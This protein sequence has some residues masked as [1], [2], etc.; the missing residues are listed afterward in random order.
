M[1]ERLRN[2]SNLPPF[3]SISRALAFAFAPLLIG[4]LIYGTYKTGPW[5]DEFW[6][7]FFSDPAVGFKDAFTN[8]WALDVHPP[9]FSFLAWLA[10]NLGLPRTIEAGRLLNF[11]PMVLAAAFVFL[12][13]KR[14]PAE[15]PFL[16]VYFPG[17]A[18][19]WQFPSAFIEF[20]SYF[21]ALCG[22]SL[23]LVCLKRIDRQKRDPLTGSNA[24]L[25]WSGYAA[26]LLICLN[27][28]FV[29]TLLAVGAVAT[30]AFA[31]LL[32]GD[33]RL[34][35]THLA[36][37]IACSLPLVVTTL[38]QWSYL[39]S[40]SKDFWLKTSTQEALILFAEAM[41]IPLVQ[42]T[43][44]QASW[45]IPLGLR[46]LQREGNRNDDIFAAILAASFIVGCA[47]VLAYTAATGA[48]TPRYIMP[49]CI[50][51]VALLSALTAT[52]MSRYRL[53]YA[54]FLTACLVSAIQTTLQT[55]QDLKW[56]EAADY[57]SARQKACPSARITPVRINPQD[58]TANGLASYG[59]A[60][61]YLAKQR[62]MTI[63]AV[64]MPPAAPKST[65]CPDYYWI[66]NLASSGQSTTALSALITK[67][68]PNLN[69]CNIKMTRFGLDA[70]V[71][72]VAD[73]AP[74][75]Q[76]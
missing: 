75:C 19:L 25:V 63:G 42:S 1:S 14:N 43:L 49:V 23:L 46:V 44:L 35:L 11:I 13:W 17:V 64:D 45:L 4:M 10:A 3:V 30:F 37:G 66:D 50:T 47:L 54:V 22:Y 74:E 51:T 7:L 58:R 12:F 61:G 73:G 16:A 71:Y 6:T 72:E 55:A 68:F 48:L 8:R 31:A 33:R 26:V 40:M 20:R 69:G 34:F 18:A 21:L 41:I 67:R 52:L 53:L 39:S 57:L 59:V 38:L 62:G 9:L 56:S 2:F 5:Y 32:R 60:Y 76:R 36:L 24:S 65:T 15:R 70:A 29:T 28:H 27:I